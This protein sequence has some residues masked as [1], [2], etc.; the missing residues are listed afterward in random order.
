MF[1]ILNLQRRLDHNHNPKTCFVSSAIHATPQVPHATLDRNLGPLNGDVHMTITSTSSISTKHLDQ[2]RFPPPDPNLNGSNG[3]SGA[4][5]PAALD[6]PFFPGTNMVAT[7]SSSPRQHGSKHS[8]PKKG[9]SSL[10]KQ[11]QT[12]DNSTYGNSAMAHVVR[13]GDAQSAPHA[14]AAPPSGPI[15]GS[16]RLSRS[17]TIEK[18]IAVTNKCACSAS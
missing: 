13:Q 1:L 15:V 5:T 6:I 7:S 18:E 14:D 11:Q 2:D 10:H 3:K 12:A 16:Q 4:M 9:Q 17:S 8:S